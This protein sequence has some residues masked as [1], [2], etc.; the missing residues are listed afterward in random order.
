MLGYE[1]MKSPTSSQ[2]TEKFVGSELSLRVSTQ[3][4][5]RKINRWVFNQNLAIWRG[6]SST[7]GQA[8]KLIS[9]PSPTTKTRRLS[10]NSTHPGLLPASLPDII[11]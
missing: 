3:I 8:R 6:P 10:F 7:Q 11:P 5:K 2:E 4:V 1:E 9:G